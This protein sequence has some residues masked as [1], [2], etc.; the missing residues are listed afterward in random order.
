MKNR[1][2]K[3]TEKGKER[4]KMKNRK[5]KRKEKATQAV[6]NRSPHLLRKRSHFGTGYSTAPPPKA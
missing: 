1:K 6:M 5:R 4:K 2:R 3:R